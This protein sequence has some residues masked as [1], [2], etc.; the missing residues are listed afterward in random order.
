[1]RNLSVILVALAVQVAY[2]HY[3]GPFLLWGVENLN[4]MKIPTLQAIED[5]NLRD[6][7]TKASAIVIFIRNATTK[8]SYENFPE[9][10]DIIGKN[11]WLYLPQELLSSDPLEY[12]VNA[13]VFT[14]T[15]PAVMQD[16]EIAAFYRDAQINFGR[17][18][19]LGILAA[20][21]ENPEHLILKREVS[22]P[23]MTST[24]PS[25]TEAATTP[26]NDEPV[27]DL[28]YEAKGKGILY[29]TVV[30]VL[31]IGEEKYELKK[32]AIATGDERGDMFRLSIK[33]IVPEN[34]ITI[35]F[36]FDIVGG[37]WVLNQ[38]EYDDMSMTLDIVGK[39]P[40]APIGFSFVC[41]DTFVFKKNSTSLTLKN[42]QVQPLLDGAE[43]FG[44]AYDCTGFMT[45][46]ILSGIFVTSILLIALTIGMTAILDI[47]TPN[48]FENRNS[49]PLTF[50]V[51][52]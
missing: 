15:G 10:S 32:H 49:K 24:E 44:R 39:P 27:E 20:R 3:Q 12:N 41:G 4:E 37:N 7:Y 26:A 16:N 5:Q 50:T 40:A 31:K 34:T 36:I 38:A 35:R 23:K 42:I 51:Q 33:F 28:I 9:L 14:L 52:E 18:N 46:P 11:E 8:L 6:I 22:E 29:T 43:R 48:R 25:T 2:G 30:P 13:E 21:S 1:M 19:I 45:V 47:K 17:K